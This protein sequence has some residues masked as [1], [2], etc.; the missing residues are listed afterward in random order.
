MLPCENFE[1][2]INVIEGL[3]KR[4]SPDYIRELNKDRMKYPL[5]TELNIPVRVDARERL[6][7]RQQSDQLILVPDFLKKS[8][9]EK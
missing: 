6:R 9:S 7:W 8:E 3:K 2:E 4:L 5:R 1:T